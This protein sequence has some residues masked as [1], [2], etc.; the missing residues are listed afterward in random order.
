MIHYSCD[1]CA[2]DL[3][4]EA[5]FVVKIEAFAAHD[6]AALTD[7]DLDD[8]HMEAISQKIQEMEDAGEEAELTPSSK[9]F[10]HDL[11]SDCYRRFLL[12]PLGRDHSQK[13]AFSKN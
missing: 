7:D 6:P 5:R 13:V 3:N 8:D 11:C 4:D 9:R 10:R 12:D 2:K 1:L